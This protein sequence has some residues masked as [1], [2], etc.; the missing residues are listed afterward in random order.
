MHST[1]SISLFDRDLF[2]LNM[3]KFQVETSSPPE[4]EYRSRDSDGRKALCVIVS[5]PAS[6]IT[7]TL[8]SED[9]CRF[10][11]GFMEKHG[12][13]SDG[14]FEY[15][16]AMVKADLGKSV[17]IPPRMQVKQEPVPI[18]ILFSSDQLADMQL[19]RI[20]RVLRSLPVFP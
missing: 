16:R 2:E 20:K 10:F 12:M 15:V 9:D 3:I 19:T 5:Y 11:L 4:I 6:K 17:P 8:R 18:V 13:I 7:V 1:V 14:G